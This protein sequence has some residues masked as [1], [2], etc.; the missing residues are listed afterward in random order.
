MESGK[1]DPHAQSRSDGGFTVIE[2]LVALALSV[3]VFG[4]L[5]ASVL[6]ALRV[7]RENRFQQV[8]VG[9]A[10]SHVEIARSLEWDEMAMSSVEDGSPL[11]DAG[12]T[13][14][15]ASMAGLDADEALVVDSGGAVAPV[16]T[17]DVDGAQFVVWSHVS[18]AGDLRR[19]F[20]HV[21]WDI[22]GERRGFQTSSLVSEVSAR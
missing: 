16:L 22:A 1:P 11:V 13:Y 4:F 5:T 9:I 6:G 10:M 17:E 19:F 8:A 21:G 15:V 20:V 12:A 14:L 2:A 7:S 3:L 18:E